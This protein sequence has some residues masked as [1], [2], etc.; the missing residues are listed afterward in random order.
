MLLEYATACI[1]HLHFMFSMLSYKI[2]ES[3]FHERLYLF[4][5]RDYGISSL[6]SLIYTILLNVNVENASLL[7]YMTHFMLLIHLIIT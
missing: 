3:P 7:F 2:M 4:P 6:K 1:F 5:W